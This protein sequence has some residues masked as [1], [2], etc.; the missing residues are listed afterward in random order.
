[1]NFAELGLIQPLSDRCKSLGFTEPTPIQRQAIPILLGGSDLI[2]CAA[3]GTGKTA[4]FLLPMLQTLSTTKR[5]GVRMLILSPTRELASQITDNLG[6]LDAKRKA[7]PVTIVGGA[8]AHRQR[9]ELRNGAQVVIATPGRLMDHVES[10]NINLSRVEVLVL[11]EAD[12]MLDMGFLPVIRQIIGLL[13]AERQTL[14]FSATMSPAVEEIAR[15]YMLDPETVDVNPR[16]KAA[17]TVKQAAYPVALES[18]TNLL[19]HLLEQEQ[20]DR[21]LVFTRTRRG[22][23][24]LATLLAAR[25]HKVNRIHADRTQSQRE[26]A[27]RG[28]RDGRYRVLVATDIAARG[29]DVDSISHVINYDVPDAAEDYVH[30]IGR[31][32]RAGNAG[33]ALTLLTPVDELSMRAI[34]KLTGQKVERIV[35]PGFGGVMPVTEKTSPTRNFGRSGGSYRSFS[36][37][38]SG[39]RRF[40]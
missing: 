39:G 8:S 32:G 5:P 31:T 1:M 17:V 18:K 4:A 27:L 40:A 13:P 22:A 38:R 25:K 11:D 35:V 28:F 14:L 21:V 19:L 23:E 2:G 16:G 26:A 7:R 29:I 33:H 15:Q 34:E 37:R 20:A 36:P 24:R 12:R 9:M 10:G 6:Q 3:T 30:R